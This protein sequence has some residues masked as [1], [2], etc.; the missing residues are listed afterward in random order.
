MTKSFKSRLRVAGSL[1][2]VLAAGL[3]LSGCS[4]FS[5]ADDVYH[6]TNRTIDNGEQSFK[7]IRSS[8][9][10][11]VYDRPFI[12]GPQIEITNETN[13]LPENPNIT[14]NAGQPISLSDAAT[15]ITRLSGIPVQV[16]S[17]V[18]SYLAGNSGGGSLPGAGSFT[19]LPN[20]QDG[21]S[22]ISIDWENRPLSGLLDLL[23]AKTGAFWEVRDGEVRFFL[24]KTQA[25]TV[26]AL[27]GSATMNA[28]I[29]NAGST[30]GSSSGI[31][32]A[33]TTSGSTNQAASYTTSLDIY[34]SI[35]EGI[36]A[37]LAQ[38]KGGAGGAIPTSVAVNQSTGQVIVTATPP[39]LRAVANYLK[40]IND[41]MAQNVVITLHV[42]SVQLN[43]SNNLGLNLSSVFQ[44][45]GA[46]YGINL[47]GV[48]PPTIS[49][50]GGSISAMILGKGNGD[51]QGGTQALVQ[52]LASNGKTSLV[53]SGSVI[54][55]NG[56]PTPLQV[57]QTHTYLA[58][59]S[60]TNS[61]NVG[62]T[63]QLTPGSYTVG[64]SGTF[65]PL[66][67]GS[68]ILLEYTVNLQQDLGLQTFTSNGSSIQEPQQAIEAF[69]QRV[70]LKSGQTLV[71]SGFGQSQ[72]TL[73]RTG[74]G[75]SRFFLLGGGADAQT[76][77]NDLVI[78][79]SVKKMAS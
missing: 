69:M 9:V 15:T 33:G 51:L 43:K 34:K 10:V 40:P 70:S 54:A 14:L 18:K 22:S 13:R 56:Q 1:A 46:N 42:Y 26:N 58:S 72:H 44:N 74:T 67:R 57:A 23:S 29:S 5:H 65:L 17:Q 45:I 8:G 38:S 12:L 20:S 50:G 78:V 75:F 64:F 36:N 27:P 7:K 6:G 73:N 61:A 53:T 79:I 35:E 55:L 30:G 63:T 3:V 68:H 31:T 49:A 25:F 39:E 32:S 21:G 16:S 76:V 24:T 19:V 2:A 41:E 47:T 28:N 59:S 11:T 37:I 66:V 52:A 62:S 77:K 71:L 4:S 48:A 60:T